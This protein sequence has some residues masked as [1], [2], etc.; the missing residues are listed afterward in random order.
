MVAAA[1]EDEVG[2][3][4]DGGVVKKEEV[5]KEEEEDE[6]VKEEVVNE[7]GSGT[8]DDQENRPED[9]IPRQPGAAGR[10]RKRQAR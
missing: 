4:A 5:V 2:A 9:A 1:V 6:V 8:N 7:L 10:A 3:G